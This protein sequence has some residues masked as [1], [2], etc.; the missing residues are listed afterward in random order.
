MQQPTQQQPQQGAPAAAAAAVTVD[1]QPGGGAA[2]LPLASVRMDQVFNWFAEQQGA[3]HKP[4]VPQPEMTL[5]QIFDAAGLYL[6]HPGAAGPGPALHPPLQQLH[7]QQQLQLLQQP[8]QVQ[9]IQQRGMAALPMA[10]PGAPLFMQ[11][12]AGLLPAGLT[13]AGPFASNSGSLPV[14]ELS[15][16][17]PDNRAA[18]YHQQLAALAAAAAGLPPT[19]PNNG[20]AGGAAARAARAKKRKAAG[21]EG[22]G[23]AGKPPIP[24]PAGGLSAAEA[25]R[26]ATAVAERAAAEL[27]QLPEDNDDQ[28]TRA[29]K[30]AVG[31]S[32]AGR[33]PECWPALRMCVAAG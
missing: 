12:A 30:R 28:E 31:A 17:P 23:G 22:P 20:G 25:A 18:A 33:Q 6:T 3:A 16:N 26:Q 2:L 8:P 13:L 9:Q 21:G 15:L 4:Q 32:C 1:L 29:I 24:H 5:E 11:Q 7:P 19:D 10:M 14:A 27:A